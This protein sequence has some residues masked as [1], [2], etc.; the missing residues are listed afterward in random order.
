[1]TA[2]GA[3]LVGPG[4]A[5]TG[6]EVRADLVQMGRDHVASLLNATAAGAR[7]TADDRRALAA[8]R[9]EHRNCFV[10]DAGRRRY[11][12]I[13]VGASCPEGY[14]PAV[15]ALLNVGGIAV[16]PCGA[17]ASAACGREKER[18]RERNR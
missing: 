16:L 7:L 3:V 8:V 10:P 11:N 9:F 5:A 15:A 14:L 18:E 17:H 13:H 12:R 4:G 6:L 1:M 2:V